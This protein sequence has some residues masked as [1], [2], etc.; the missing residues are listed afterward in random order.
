M[1]EKMREESLTFRPTAEQRK[2]LSS[3]YNDDETGMTAISQNF[4]VGRFETTLFSQIA[5]K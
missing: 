4:F 1:T 3:D 5:D 2:R